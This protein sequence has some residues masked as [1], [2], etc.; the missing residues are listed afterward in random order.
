MLSSCLTCIPCSSISICICIS[1]CLC[2]S[3]YVSSVCALCVCVSVYVWLCLTPFVQWCTVVSCKI[4]RMCL[5][6]LCELFCDRSSTNV[7]ARRDLVCL[8][9]YRSG[10]LESFLTRE[11]S[12][13]TMYSLGTRVSLFS[14]KLSAFPDRSFYLP[15]CRWDSVYE[16]VTKWK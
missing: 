1:S 4:Y 14:T 15:W 16:I 9:V 2:Q 10:P 11:L 8:Y 12:F 13:Q 7:D 6:V 3:V 5:C